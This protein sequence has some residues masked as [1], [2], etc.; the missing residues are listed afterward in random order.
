MSTLSNPLYVGGQYRN[1]TFPKPFG[2]QGETAGVVSTKNDPFSMAVSVA[3]AQRDFDSRIGVHREILGECAGARR[4]KQGVNAIAATDA[5]KVDPQQGECDAAQPLVHPGEQDEWANTGDIEI[6]SYGTVGGRQPHFRTIIPRQMG[7]ADSDSTAYLTIPN[8]IAEVRLSDREVGSNIG[9]V[10]ANN[11]RA[12]G[13]RDERACH[14]HN[15]RCG[16]GI[17]GPSDAARANA[18]LR[19]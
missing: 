4:L 10:M 17:E 6:D 15:Y 18:Y 1:V 9:V 16:A 3:D 12:E 7:G 5:G 19:K 13:M 14:Q 8:R 2:T 11:F